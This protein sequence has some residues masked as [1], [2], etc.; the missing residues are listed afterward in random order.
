MHRLRGELLPINGGRVDEAQAC[1]HRALQIARAQSARS[2]ELR[3]AL[4]L[5]KLLAGQ[6]K[7]QAARDLVQKTYRWFSEGFGTGDLREAEAL[8]KQWSNEAQSSRC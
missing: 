6:G 2:W 5:G 3:A 8:L 4:S 7:P 1:V